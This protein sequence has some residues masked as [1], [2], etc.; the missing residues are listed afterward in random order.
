MR[1]L[2]RNAVQLF[3]LKGETKTSLLLSQGVE[4][5]RLLL[6]SVISRFEKGGNMMTKHLFSSREIWKVVTS[7]TVRLRPFK[8]VQ[9]LCYIWGTH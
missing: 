3:M 8:Q 7:Y 2:N 9:K 1:L 5:K 6:C 4:K